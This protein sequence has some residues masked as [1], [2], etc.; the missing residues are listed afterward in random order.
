MKYNNGLTWFKV[1]SIT[2][3]A[4]DE[5]ALKSENEKLNAKKVKLETQNVSLK[6]QIE[7][8]KLVILNVQIHLQMIYMNYKRI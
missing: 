3:E 4:P 2:Y 8:L 5:F 1:E 6:A 7:E